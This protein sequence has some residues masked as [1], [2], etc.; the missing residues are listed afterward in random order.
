MVF[1]RTLDRLLSTD[2]KKM[3]R[4]YGNG[5]ETFVP[6]NVGLKSSINFFYRNDIVPFLAARSR[7]LRRAIFAVKGKTY[8]V[9][10]LGYGGSRAIFKN[11]RIPRLIPN[12]SAHDW[13]GYQGTYKDSESLKAALKKPLLPYPRFLRSLTLEHVEQMPSN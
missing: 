13:T 5:G 6:N 8:E 11:L 7:V 4:F 12:A 2:T 1:L 3:I 10:N 9:H